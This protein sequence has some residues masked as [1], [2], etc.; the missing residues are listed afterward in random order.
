MAAEIITRARWRA[1]FCAGVLALVCT[2]TMAAQQTTPPTENQEPNPET[3]APKKTENKHYTLKVMVQAEDSSSDNPI[4]GAE[5]TVY[6]GDYTETRSTNS[7]GEISFELRTAAKSV[8]VRVR[9]D[10]YK[11]NQQQVP[12]TADDKVYKVVLKPT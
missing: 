10:H 7:A 12:L 11:T 6:A 8:T 4:K 2:F 5:V 1:W 9:A 3:P